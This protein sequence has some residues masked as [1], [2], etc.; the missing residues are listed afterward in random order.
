MYQMGI[1]NKRSILSYGRQSIDEDDV[2]AVAAVLRG[3][4]LTTGPTVRAFEAALATK[5]H[6][7]N[8]VACANG[9]AAL[10]LCALALGLGPGDAVIV[11]S[12]TFLATANAARYVGAEVVFTDVDA[13]TGLA[14][15]EDFETALA[16]PEAAN[17]R[18]LIPVHY[19]GQ[20]CDME[21]IFDIARS[22][23]LFIVED[24]CHALGTTYRTSSGATGTVGD[25]RWSEMA[26]FSFHPVKTIAMGEG[27]GCLDHR[28]G[29]GRASGT[30]S[31]SRYDPGSGCDAQSRS[32]AGR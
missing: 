5:L 27:G 15:P 31:Q 8:V 3:D 11:P 23:E 28:S 19:A 10:H 18:A 1:P 20:C 26:C 29:I 7:N 32:V 6:A 4:W 30:I 2:A 12:V 24:A 13:E 22:R 9:T 25:C 17:A 16:R 14:R 21:R